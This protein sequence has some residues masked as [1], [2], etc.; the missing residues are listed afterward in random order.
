MAFDE[1]S[2]KPDADDA[3]KRRNRNTPA[4]GKEGGV[5]SSKDIGFMLNGV[6]IRKVDVRELGALLEVE[7]SAESEYEVL[8]FPPEPPSNERAQ[9]T[10]DKAA[11]APDWL[12]RAAFP[13]ADLF[14]PNSY[15]S[16]MTSK[17]CFRIS[18][19]NMLYYV[20][21]RF[22]DGYKGVVTLS[23]A[24]MFA[25]LSAKNE[26]L[27][28]G[29]KEIGCEHIFLA[30]LQQHGFA[31]EQLLTSLHLNNVG[32][33]RSLGNCYG[34]AQRVILGFDDDTA[35]SVN[36]IF[37]ARTTTGADTYF[38]NEAEQML[39]D[40]MYI[41]ARASLSQ[42]HSKQLLSAL[43]EAKSAT[44]QRALDALTITEKQVLAALSECPEQDR[45]SDFA[46]YFMTAIL[47]GIFRFRI[48]KGPVAKYAKFANPKR[49]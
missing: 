2:N 6:D 4:S 11:L 16:G 9:R 37:P 3:S 42:T 22:S 32:K 43:I 12:T 45:I 33:P 40:A 35:L 25:L 41:A 18:S 5:G 8:P 39:I 14:D 48:L 10:T 20:Q 28:A 17:R 15:P 36:M 7:E 49:S 21:M 13:P 26:A 1:D 27:R 29:K 44:V 23:Q 31:A 47:N 19:D 30:L 38:T 34:V 46:V 24:L